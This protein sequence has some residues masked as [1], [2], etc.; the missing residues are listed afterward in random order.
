MVTASGS[1]HPPGYEFRGTWEVQDNL[2]APVTL[3]LLHTQYKDNLPPKPLH[4]VWAKSNLK[5]QVKRGTLSP[6]CSRKPAGL[7]DMQGV[8]ED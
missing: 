4:G 5:A 7:R 3:C 6:G 8:S 1:V 2:W